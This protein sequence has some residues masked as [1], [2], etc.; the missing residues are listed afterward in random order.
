[1]SVG[2]FLDVEAA[3]LDYLR[4]E[5]PATVRVLTDLPAS[6]DGEILRVTVTGG[7]SDAL[8]NRPQVDLGAFAPTRTGM[9]TLIGRANDAIARIAGVA[10]TGDDGQVIGQFDVPDSIV[11]PVNAFWSPTV[12]HGVAVY[13]LPLRAF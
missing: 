4:A 7:T 5:L 6:I 3:L 8:E 12:Q 2:K 10:I 9:W 1:M 11:H 13:A